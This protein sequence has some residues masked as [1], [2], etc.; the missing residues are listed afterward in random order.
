[1]SFLDNLFGGATQ[2][3]GAQILQSL[4][5]D[6]NLSQDQIE[7]VKGFFQQ[8]RSEKQEAKAEGDLATKID[9]IKQEF[10]DHVNSILSDEQKQK[11]IANAEKYLSMF[12]GG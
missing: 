3:V 10:K 5:S 8:F 1:M 4:T 11:F 2:G 6:L 7:K 12:H 9:G